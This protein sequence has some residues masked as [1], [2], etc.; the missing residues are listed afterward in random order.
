MIT[1]MVILGF[2][3]IQSVFA[4]R[5]VPVYIN[6]NTVKTIMNE[7]PENSAV[8]GVSGKKLNNIFRKQLRMN[9]LYDLANDKEAFKFSKIKGGYNI[10]LHFEERGPIFGNLEFVV[11][12]DHQV[13]VITK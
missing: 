1:W 2:L 8:K 6:Y 11:T 10:A 5:V 7:L 4:L 13:D 12:F 3:A 9:S